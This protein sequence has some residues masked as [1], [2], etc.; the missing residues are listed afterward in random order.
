MS[1]LAYC[2][3]GKREE[4]SRPGEREEEEQNLVGVGVGVGEDK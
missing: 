2:C 1:D 4:G 3:I